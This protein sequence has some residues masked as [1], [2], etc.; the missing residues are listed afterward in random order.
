MM[1]NYLCCGVHLP[2]FCMLRCFKYT[3]VLMFQHV[4][5]QRQKLTGSDFSSLFVNRHVFFSLECDKSRFNRF[6]R[7]N[8]PKPGTTFCKRGTYSQL[9]GDS[10]TRVLGREKLTPWRNCWC[11][12]TQQPFV[13]FAH[14]YPVQFFKKTFCIYFRRKQGGGRFSPPQRRDR[15]DIL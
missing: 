8:F 10:Q 3:F 6:K 4:Q 1:S 2:P 15:E 11:A 13:P 14:M 9:L 5:K 12:F 7:Q